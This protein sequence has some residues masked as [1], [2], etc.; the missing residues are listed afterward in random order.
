MAES[1]IQKLFAERIGGSGF[2][3]DTKIYKFQKIKMAK[4]EALKA[5]PGKEILDFGVGE[6]DEMAYPPV[7]DRLKTETDHPENRGYSDNGIQ[8]FKDAAARYMKNIFGVT[9]DPQSEVN[10]TIGSKPALAMFPACFINPGDIT[11]MTVP[12]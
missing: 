8:E 3:K 7:R 10:H 9:I 11:F 2:G 12:G 6:P 1:Y 4:M 5:N